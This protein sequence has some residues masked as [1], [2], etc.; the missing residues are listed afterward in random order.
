MTKVGVYT[1]V[2]ICFCV[3][4]IAEWHESW[5]T[6]LFTSALCLLCGATVVVTDPRT[7]ESEKTGH[8]QIG[9]TLLVLGI[10]IGFVA[11]YRK[12]LLA[13][14][15]LDFMPL[16]ALAVPSALLSILA[17]KWETRNKE[18]IRGFKSMV[19][20]AGLLLIWISLLSY[21]AF[22]L[23]GEAEQLWLLRFGLF[24]ALAGLLLSVAGEGRSR[25]SSATSA[26]LICS[27]WLIIAWSPA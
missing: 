24:A 18:G 16:L 10:V 4:W 13:S 20:F 2:L 22:V 19:F 3:A 8:Q 6:D 27:V 15:A 11:L 17:L 12:Y 25:A 21:T 14:T 1:L 26:A 5:I 7:E 9:L 23:A